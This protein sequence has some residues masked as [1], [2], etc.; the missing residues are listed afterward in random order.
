VGKYETGVP[1]VDEYET[2]VPSPWAKPP[3]PIERP[4]AEDPSDDHAW[5]RFKH[6]CRDCGGEYGHNPVCPIGI[7]EDARTLSNPSRIR[8]IRSILKSGIYDPRDD[9][10]ESAAEHELMVK[11]FPHLRHVGEL[12]DHFRAVAARLEE[13]MPPRQ[14]SDR[15][16]PK[17]QTFGDHL[18][19][20]SRDG[21]RLPAQPRRLIQRKKHH[22]ATLFDDQKDDTLGDKV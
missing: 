1:F 5:G 22:G 6:P 14:A 12:S 19:L 15:P 8:M 18:D 20:P 10:M 4:P 7:E 17:I 2:G 9:M 13:I 16:P 21:F 3:K 11:A